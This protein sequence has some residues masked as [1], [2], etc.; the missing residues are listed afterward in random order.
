MDAAEVDAHL[1][2]PADARRPRPPDARSHFDARAREGR[3]PGAHE[4]MAGL[5]LREGR[6]DEARRHV[7][8]ALAAAPDD[9][10]ALQRRAESPRARGRA[11][12]RRPRA[13]RRPSAR[14]P[15]WSGRWPPTP[16]SP[17]PPTCSPGCGPRRCA[18]RIALMRRA[19]ARQPE[20]AELAFTL[21]GLH[22]KRNELAEAARVLRRARERTRD[23]AHRF[24]AEHLLA[25][26]GAVRLRPGR[27]PRHAGGGGVPR[28]RRAGLPG[29]HAS[30]LLRLAAASPRACS[31]T[32]QRRHRGARPHLRPGFA[33]R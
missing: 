6:L 21:A 11:P 7:E 29:A 30:G 14:W 33:A 31:S 5:L 10:R 28:R 24:L 9:A 26:I 18:D 20:R 12:R 3:S 27:G 13:K 32:T 16:T 19:V 2:G 23:E 17:T 4:A 8:A 22:I 15:C 25:K 1:G